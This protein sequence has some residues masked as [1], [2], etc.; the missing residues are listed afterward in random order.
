MVSSIGRRARKQTA[1]GISSIAIINERKPPNI[2][3]GSKI[4]S[5]LHHHP[6]SMTV[7]TAIIFKGGV[8]KAD[9]AF[10]ARGPRSILKRRPYLFDAHGIG[11]ARMKRKCCLPLK[12]RMPWRTQA[13]RAACRRDSAPESDNSP[14][15][16][17]NRRASARAWRLGRRRDVARNRGMAARP[18]SATDLTRRSDGRGAHKTVIARLKSSSSQYL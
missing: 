8:G 7:E 12:R 5:S 1:V 17:L 2:S 6:T 4:K 10:V 11:V 18:R 9:R 15:W 14:L 13:P 3:N 16:R